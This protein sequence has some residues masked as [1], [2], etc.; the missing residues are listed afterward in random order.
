[1]AWSRFLVPVSTLQRKKEKKGE[2][3]LLDVE[4]K[5]GAMLSIRL[6]QQDQREGSGARAWQQ[7]LGL[8]KYRAKPPPKPAIPQSLEYMRHY[9]SDM[10]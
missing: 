5:C 3:G 10:A 7:Y 2:W 4:A 6:W 9:A 1:M 8:L